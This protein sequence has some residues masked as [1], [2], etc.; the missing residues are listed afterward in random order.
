MTRGAASLLMQTLLLRNEKLWIL[1]PG[2][3]EKTMDMAMQVNVV[4]FLILSIFPFD[5]RFVLT[6]RSVFKYL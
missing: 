3:C 2:V 6:L 4:S 5:Q 1:A